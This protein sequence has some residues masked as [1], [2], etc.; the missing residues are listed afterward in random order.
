MAH[1]QVPC[2][3]KSQLREDYINERDLMRERVLQLRSGVM[4][5]S[6]KWLYQINIAIRE[7][8]G[9]LV[10]VEEKLRILHIPVTE[11]QL[12]ESECQT[13]TKK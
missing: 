7:M 13:A 1:C 3:E 2:C 8:D 5:F 6:G 9:R 4:Y 12:E 11:R 10:E